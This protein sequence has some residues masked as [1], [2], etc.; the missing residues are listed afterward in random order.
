MADILISENITGT[1]IDALRQTHDVSFQPELWKDPIAL[2]E[3]VRGSRASSC[4]T[5]PR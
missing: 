4:A 3:A 5:R 2:R 1:P